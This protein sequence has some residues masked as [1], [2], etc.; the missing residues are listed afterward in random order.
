MKE[1]KSLSEA[2][3][4]LNIE[5]VLERGNSEVTCDN[6]PPPKLIPEYVLLSPIFNCSPQS[7]HSLLRAEVLVMW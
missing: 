7:V 3:E 1:F 5:Y 4:A 6:S 2:Q